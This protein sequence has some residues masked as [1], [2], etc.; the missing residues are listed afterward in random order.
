MY[1]D[2]SQAAPRHLGPAGQEIKAPADPGTSWVK[3]THGLLGPSF[4]WDGLEVGLEVFLWGILRVDWELGPQPHT[5]PPAAV[6]GG[7]G[8]VAPRHPFPGPAGWRPASSGPRR[9]RAQV[10]AVRSGYQG[11]LE[12]PPKGGCPEQGTRTPSFLGSL[13]ELGT[14]SL[15]ASVSF[16]RSPSESKFIKRL[17]TPPLAFTGARAPARGC[18]SEHWASGEG[19]GTWAPTPLGSSGLGRGARCPAPH[20][21][22][23]RVPLSLGHD[24]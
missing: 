18:T 19:G 14:P 6:I 1:T 23:P 11:V 21:A 2:L 4:C 8:G 20:Q 5:V 16:L 3:K 10:R 15:C 9:C 24:L 22:Q 17:V 13:S 7:V 12:A